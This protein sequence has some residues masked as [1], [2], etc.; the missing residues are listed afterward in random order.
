MASTIRELQ[1]GHEYLKKLFHSLRK[2]DHVP[3][4][5]SEAIASYIN[6]ANSTDAFKNAM[7]TEKLIIYMRYVALTTKYIVPPP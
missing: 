3:F 7:M 2:K 4:F 1:I 5:K 6:S